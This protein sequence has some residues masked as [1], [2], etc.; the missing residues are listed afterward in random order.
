MH[1]C[2][3]S[4]PIHHLRSTWI[5]V[6]KST[7]KTGVPILVS[8]EALWGA[9]QFACHGTGLVPELNVSFIRWVIL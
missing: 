8:F 9:Q 3:K 6:L 2:P 1:D 4:A 5:F 7:E